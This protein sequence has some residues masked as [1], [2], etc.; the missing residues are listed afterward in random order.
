MTCW[1]FQA[2]LVW[3]KE[4]GLEPPAPA[5]FD[6]LIQSFSLSQVTATSVSAYLSTYM[7]AKR[8]ESVLS[9]FPAHIGPHFKAQLAASSFEDPCLFEESA[10]AAVS[11]AAREDSQLEAQLSIAKAFTLP[12]F[13]GSARGGKRGGGQAPPAGASGGYRGRGRGYF[14][15]GKRKASASPGRGRGAK[16]PRGGSVGVGSGSSS[17]NPSASAGRGFQK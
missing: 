5:L 1:L 6:Q 3:L 11:S 14:R 13:G 2:L 7:Q 4:L 12:V 10:L 17:E 8:R 9:H 15:G 16:S